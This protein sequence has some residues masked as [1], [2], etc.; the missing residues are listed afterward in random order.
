MLVELQLIQVITQAGAVGIVIYLVL[1][2]TRTHI[3][4]QR[5]ERAAEAKE[6]A[7]QLEYVTNQRDALEEAADGRAKQQRE[8]YL[9]ALREIESRVEREADECRKERKELSKQAA[10]DREA[11][12]LARQELSTMMQKALAEIHAVLVLPNRAAVAD[13]DRRPG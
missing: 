1:W 9:A 12:R 5:E 10:Q 2:L 8:D 11:D 6:R 4:A 13:Q 3:P 7:A